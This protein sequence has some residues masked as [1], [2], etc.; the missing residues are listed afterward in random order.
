MK[1]FLLLLFISTNSI[2]FSFAQDVITKKNGDDILG[3]VIKVSETSVEYK[4]ADNPDGPTYSIEKKE[5]FMIRYQN[6]TKDV[7]NQEVEESQDE[8]SEDSKPKLSMLEIQM[9]GQSDAKRCYKASDP[10]AGEIM[11]TML[12]TPIIGV[13]GGIAMSSTAP[14]WDH[15]KMPNSEYKMDPIYRTAYIEQAKKMKSGKVW[16]G[17]RC[18]KASPSCTYEL[19]LCPLGTV[20]NRA[21]K[22]KT[23][24]LPCGFVYAALMK[25]FS[26]SALGGGTGNP[27]S[28]NPSI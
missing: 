17:S 1:N 13:L 26:A 2:V 21:A 6:G 16:I 11:L 8:N 28:F 25:T 18:A 9:T 23:R 19:R 5:L 27:S 22:N 3:K 14:N 24:S 7:F 4:R 15:L 10:Q 12:F 20:C